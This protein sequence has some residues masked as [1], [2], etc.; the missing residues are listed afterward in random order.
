V[1]AVPLTISLDGNELWVAGTATDTTGGIWYTPGNVQL[2]Q[3][4]S[5]T[6]ARDLRIAGGQL[7]GDSN[8][9]PPGLGTVGT[10]T[11]TSGSPA[12][13]TLS[14]LPTSG[15]PS[16][17]GFAFFDLNPSVPGID[18]LYIADDRQTGGGGIGK[19]TLS[20]GGT[21]TVAWAV[22]G[23]GSPD[24]GTGIGYRGLAGYAT[25]TNVTL[26]ATTGMT[27][28]TADSLVVIVDTGTGN[29]TQT[30]VATAPTNETFRGVAL[31]PHP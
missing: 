12:L 7:Y 24:A 4:G 23:G 14:G 10:G 25:G 21:W 28:G 20:T 30:V 16:P 8:A 17:Y 27:K 19:W 22:G 5:S 11:P 6:T 31:P 2:V 1:V 18:T 9:D 13:T 3:T 15:S 26:M 29:P